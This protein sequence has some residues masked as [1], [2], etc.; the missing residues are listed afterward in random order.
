MSFLFRQPDSA[1]MAAASNVQVRTPEEAGKFP[2]FCSVS[3]SLQSDIVIGNYPA[4]SSPTGSQLGELWG[5]LRLRRVCK[6]KKKK[7]KLEEQDK[8]Q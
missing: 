8:K 6:K 7:H 4:E 2:L 3:A 5:K 1:T